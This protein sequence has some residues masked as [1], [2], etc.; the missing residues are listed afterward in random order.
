MGAPTTEDGLVTQAEYARMRGCSR[1][2]V[3]KAVDKGRITAFGDKKR[4]HPTLADTQ[5]QTNTRARIGSR[6]SADDLPSTGQPSAPAQPP[7]SESDYTRDRARREKADAD[8][9]EM[10][11]MQRR[12][13][14]VRADA[15]REGLAS[16]LGQ[17]RE[18]I[19]QLPARL[20]PQLVVD[21]DQARVQML[22][23]A[24]LRAV[25]IKLTEEPI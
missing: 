11:L 21:T 24:E 20:A 22:L 16:R 5:W 12:G 6:G 17:V 3:R 7:S 23:D 9:R 8:L 19:L 2:S 25:L 15:V 10:E 18:A 1:E 14:L 13:E 4:I